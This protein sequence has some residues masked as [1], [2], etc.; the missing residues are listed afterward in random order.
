MPIGISDIDIP[1][2]QVDCTAERA[3]IEGALGMRQNSLV[4]QD[5]NTRDLGCGYSAELQFQSI[6]SPDWRQLP[7]SSVL[8]HVLHRSLVSAAE[9]IAVGIAIFTGNR[10]MT[11]CFMVIGVSMA[12]TFYVMASSFD[13]LVEATALHIALE[14]LRR[15]VPVIAILRCRHGSLSVR[16]GGI[17]LDTLT[18]EP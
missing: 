10:R 17:G 4:H 11:E 7:R 3:G 16:S 14:V 15:P 18:D 12:M 1:D 2:R 9:G 5:T 8:T 6:L 13:A